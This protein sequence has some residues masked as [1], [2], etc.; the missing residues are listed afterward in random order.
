MTP[1]L[2]FVVSNFEF[3]TFSGSGVVFDPGS[4]VVLDCVNS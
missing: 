2:S 4:G 1:W 3:V